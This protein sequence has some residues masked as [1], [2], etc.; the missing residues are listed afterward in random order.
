MSMS[1]ISN[2]FSNTQTSGSSYQLQNSQF[3][4]LGKD[5]TSGNLAAAQSDFNTLQQAFAQTPT[6]AASSTTSNPVAQAFQQLATDLKSGNLSG[7]K[8]DYSTIQQDLNSQTSVR[9]PHLQH[10]SG[11]GGGGDQN[12]LLQDLNQLGQD[13]SSSTFLSGN[14]SAAQQAYGAPIQALFPGGTGGLGAGL[15]A[16][17]IA[18]TSDFALSFMA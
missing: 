10:H 17:S 14:L 13:L 16:S 12:T 8:Q 3:Q 1:A 6:A 9:R 18:P 11:G 4:Q 2:L 15:Q 5:L 7:A